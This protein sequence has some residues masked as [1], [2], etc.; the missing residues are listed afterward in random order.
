M[1]EQPQED[2]LDARLREEAPYLDDA[3][4][5]GCVL[6]QLPARRQP[7]SLRGAIM[8]A[9][10]LVACVVAY[11]AS[12]GGAFLGNA[13]AFLVAMPIWTVALLAG[14]CGLLVMVLGTAAAVKT[15]RGRR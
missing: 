8:A 15:T 6:Q 9:V 11:F 10:T 13:A 2:W 14:L 12:G 1:D 5:T 4:F 7:R 3:G